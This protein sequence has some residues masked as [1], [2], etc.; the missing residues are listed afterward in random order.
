LLNKL[1][2]SLERNSTLT[3]LN[4]GPH[5]GNDELDESAIAKALRTNT[6][7]VD[8]G[9]FRR[10]DI[11][12]TLAMNAAVANNKRELYTNLTRCWVRAQR[13][14]DPRAL[15]CDVPRELIDVIVSSLRRE[16]RGADRYSGFT[17][18]ISRDACLAAISVGGSA[19]LRSFRDDSAS[20]AK[21]TATDAQLL[22]PAASRSNAV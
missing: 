7:L 6:T 17:C 19:A 11:N 18:H 21:R 14:T 9:V 12:E 5:C 1:G 3:S 10:L 4:V 15:L 22:P 2:Q 20:H 16:T 8:A 13:E